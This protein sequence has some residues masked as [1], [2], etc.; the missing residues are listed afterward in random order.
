M[1][2]FELDL[3]KSLLKLKASLLKQFYKIQRYSGTND[4][5]SAKSRL[6]RKHPQVNENICKQNCN[7]VKLFMQ[8]T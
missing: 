8:S 3:S 1:I 6:H 4:Y 5:F 7:T 2:Y